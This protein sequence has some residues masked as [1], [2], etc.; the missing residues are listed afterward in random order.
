MRTFI[1]LDFE[2]EFFDEIEVIVKKIKKKLPGKWIRR[3]NWHL[4]LAFLGNIDEKT[5]EETKNF[6]LSLEI[7]K[8]QIFCWKVDYSPGNFPRM[9]WVHFKN[10]NMDVFTPIFEKYKVN[11][12]YP[13]LNLLRFK[14]TNIKK[15]PKIFVPLNYYVKPKRITFY[16]SILQRPF[17]KYLPIISKDF[18]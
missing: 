12:F 13:H 5:L 15:L 16:Q 2:D 18:V 8:P 17:A 7:K 6:L 14:P 11:D 10:E 9:V 3:E 1:A 4:T